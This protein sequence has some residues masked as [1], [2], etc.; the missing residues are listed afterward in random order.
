MSYN[1]RIVAI[2]MYV[3]VVT[4]GHHSVSTVWS[5][6]SQIFRWTFNQLL[7]K[8]LNKKPLPNGWCHHPEVIPDRIHTDIHAFTL[9]YCMHCVTW[10]WWSYIGNKNLHSCLIGKGPWSEKY[11]VYCTCI[12][13]WMYGVSLHFTTVNSYS[14]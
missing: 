6:K 11:K 5:G 12:V 1:I 8:F 10:K 7:S 9:R 13:S 2:L 3:H 14:Y 4:I